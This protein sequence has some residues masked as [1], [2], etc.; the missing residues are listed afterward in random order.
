MQKDKHRFI[1]QGRLLVK[2][3]KDPID[4]HFKTCAEHLLEAVTDWPAININEPK[5]LVAELKS[6]IKK[7]LTFDNLDDYLK[8]LLLDLGHNCWKI[9]SVTSL[10]EMFDFDR[11]KNYD[12]TIELEMIIARLTEHYG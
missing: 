8:N 9:E 7:P 10:L 12:K 3:E 6:E 5:D 11:T 1:S 4:C 2:V